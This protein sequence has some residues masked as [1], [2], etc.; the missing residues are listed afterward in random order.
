MCASFQAIFNYITKRV[1]N[2]NISIRQLLV[3]LAGA[4]VLGFLSMASAAPVAYDV[5]VDTSP[6]AGTTGFLD[7]QFN[8]GVATSPEATVSIT[9]FSPT[10][11]VQGAPTLDGGASGA[12]PT[13][14]AIVNSGAFNA[15]FQ[16]VLFGSGFSFRIVFDGAFLTSPS[17][18]GT[19]FSLNLFDDMGTTALGLIDPAGS[20][21]TIELI[22]GEVAQPNTG[23]ALPVGN[24]PGIRIS[25]AANEVPV[26]AMVWLLALGLVAIRR[27]R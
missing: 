2:M 6:Y 3:S 17:T 11:I 14:A 9:N 22:D 24:S 25:A 19:T 7:F 10:G 15:L 26:P 16:Q 20:L 5:T 18:D 12:L 1:I 8:P 27:T 21:L 13:G 23:N 4:S